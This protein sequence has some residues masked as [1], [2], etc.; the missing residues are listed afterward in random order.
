[1]IRVAGIVV[2]SLALLGAGSAQALT[3]E[4]VGGDFT[5]PTYVTSDPGDANRLFVVEREGTIQLVENGVVSEF[6][7][8]R[9]EV[10]C[11]GSCVGERGMMSIALSPDFAADRRLFVG[12]GDD[13]DGKIHVEE[14]KAFPDGKS[15]DPATLKPLLEID[16][17]GATNHYGGQLQFGP[18]RALYISTG[19][20][21]AE[22]DTLHNAQDPNSLLGKILR[23]DPDV[24]PPAATIW[25][26]GLRNPFR[27]SFD[28]L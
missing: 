24:A 1:M 3:L 21:S 26:S 13:V 5:E 19:D 16:H 9:T 25:S 7:D 8:L 20:G 11:A 27:F 17:P 28:R 23:L 2:A 18:D 14:L 22:D 4:Q 10:G 6:A 15:A 12:Y